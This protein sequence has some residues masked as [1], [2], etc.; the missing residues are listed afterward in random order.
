MRRSFIAA[1]LVIA[2]F[3]LAS[4]AFGQGQGQ[5]QAPQARKANRQRQIICR[6]ATIPTGWILIDDLRD[7]SMCGGD[8][9]RFVNM[10][11]VWA[12][13][14][15]DHLQP[16]AELTVCASAPTPAGWTLVDVYRD[17]SL[18]G[19]TEDLFATNVKVIRKR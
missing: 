3:T 11:N 4:E 12:I 18:C 15:F 2:T 5:G 17:K 19:H 8:N 9:P 10:Y 14:K 13:E 7:T 1:A 16:G 6:G